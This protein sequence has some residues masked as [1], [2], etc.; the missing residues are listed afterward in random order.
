[1][2][3]FSEA[4]FER[5]SAPHVARAWFCEIDLPSGVKRL[6]S[7]VGRVTAGGFE[8][9]GVSD[10]IGGQLVRVE[11]VEDPRFGQAAAVAITIG[12]IS[13]EFWTEIKT[14]AR[15]ME[16][17][18]FDLHWASF[19]PETGIIDVTLKK[20][21]P[22]KLSS[23]ALFRSFGVRHCVFTVESLWQSQN[24]PFGGRWNA[25]DQERRFS[26]D[27][28]GQFIGVKVQEIFN[29]AEP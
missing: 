4:D 27:L 1:M 17:D 5:L 21:F 22:G 15:E 28:G 25:A 12:G 9:R 18:R 8:W 14:T 24:Y 23:P 20:L 29:P 2:P 13:A 3:I 10:P 16:G 19:D 7:G 6:H 11:A 26:G